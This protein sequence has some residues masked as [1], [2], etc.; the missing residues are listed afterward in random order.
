[1]PIKRNSETGETIEEPTRKMG[2]KPRDDTY[3]FVKGVPPRRADADSSAPSTVPPG[4]TDRSPPPRD[5]G[6][7]PFDAPTQPLRASQPLGPPAEPTHVLRPGIS[8]DEETEATMANPVVGWLVVIGGPG[9]GQV[10]PVG[11]GSNTLG[12]GEDSRVRLDFGDEQISREAHAVVTYDGRGRKFYLQHGGGTNLT[13]LGD[14]PVLVPTLLDAMQDFYIG[15]TTL[16]F[17]PFC[18]PE[19]DWQ[20]TSD[21]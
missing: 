11:Y 10:R 19:F 7:S 16:R 15:A 9:R 1:M 5:A 12:R 21:G 4:R 6:S 13:Y 8:A 18:G 3:E 20:D 2:S 14:E 17:V